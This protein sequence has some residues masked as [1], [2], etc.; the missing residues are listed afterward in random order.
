MRGLL[1]FSKLSERMKEVL[2]GKDANAVEL[3]AELM[4]GL[5][6]RAI[7][8]FANHDPEY[9]VLLPTSTELHSSASRT[10]LPLT[11]ISPALLHRHTWQGFIAGL[12]PGIC[13]Q[14]AVPLVSEDKVDVLAKACLSEISLKGD[15]HMGQI[16]NIALDKIGE[17]LL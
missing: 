14:P 8:V 7:A 6:S 16:L 12:I 3:R 5:M 4:L 13:R 9:R 10:V 2:D 15:L 1:V 11:L 17:Y